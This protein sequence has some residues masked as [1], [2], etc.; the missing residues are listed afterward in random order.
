MIACTKHPSLLTV[1][2]RCFLKSPL[3][4]FSFLSLAFLVLPLAHTISS[5]AVTASLGYNG[6]IGVAERFV[7]ERFLYREVVFV[8]GRPVVLDGTLT[9]RRSARQGR[10][11]TTYTFNLAN[12]EQDAA[13]TRVQIHATT[14]NTLP[15][16]QISRNTELSRAPT[17]VIRIGGNT[18][19]LISETFTRSGLTDPRPAIDYQA[20]EF[21][22]V[23][24]FRIGNGAAAPTVTVESSGSVH[25]YN[26]H[27]SSTQTLKTKAQITWRGP[28]GASWGGTAEISASSSR[29][30][31]MSYRRNE[32]APISFDG[33]YIRT[34]WNEALLKYTAIL[35]EFD[36][37]GQATDRMVELSD[38]LSLDTEPISTRLM[39]PDIRHLKGHFAEKP[40]HVLYGLGIIPGTGEDFNPQKHLTRA[41]FV[42]QAVKVFRA[43]PLDPGIRTPA[44]AASRRRQTEVLL[45]FGDI[46]QG[47]KFLPEILDASNRGMIIGR[48]LTTF[49][50]DDRIIRAEAI[51]IAIRALGLGNMA[52]WPNAVAPFTDNDSIPAFAR[53]AAAVAEE[54]GVVEPDSEG[55]FRPRDFITAAE[56]AEL[57]YRF[58]NYMGDGLVTDYSERITAW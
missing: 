42:A 54:I 4:V 38:E 41:E 35:P 20:G 14:V 49:R 18:Y 37:D 34:T 32:P 21:R 58:I 56:A 45:P 47:D 39:V 50:P 53:N 17:E 19:T 2:F 25:S 30:Q 46:S 22:S 3:L 12:A 33:G 55:K 27:W 10:E 7:Q 43:V 31:K 13:M 26:Q 24:V 11:T 1:K 57:F 28:E 36:K 5:T 44:T 52:P 6:G 29:R 16:G 8:S 40:I 51:V 48:G 9:L 23:K 15:N